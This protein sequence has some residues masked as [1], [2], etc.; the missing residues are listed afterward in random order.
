M[1]K[2]KNE[3]AVNLSIS[4]GET[5]VSFDEAGIAEVAPEVSETLL[6]FVNEGFLL[7]EE[8]EDKKEDKDEKKAPKKAKKDE[9]VVE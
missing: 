4:V 8:Q 3:K 2:I 6:S 5:L 1:P 7:V 9:P